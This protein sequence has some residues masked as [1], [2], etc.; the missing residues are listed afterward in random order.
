VVLALLNTV[1]GRLR[2]LREAQI[3]GVAVLLGLL[4]AIFLFADMGTA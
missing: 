1:L 3:L 4:A 2:L